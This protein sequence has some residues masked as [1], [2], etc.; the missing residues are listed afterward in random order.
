MS[1]EAS[2]TPLPFE[3]PVQA[4]QE[5]TWWGRTALRLNAYRATPEEQRIVRE[6]SRKVFWGGIVGTAVPGYFAIRLGRRYRWSTIRRAV[7]FGAA[8]SFGGYVGTIMAAASA[9]RAI[10]SMPNSQLVNIFKQ[11]INEAAVEQG[12]AP[13]YEI[14][15][16]E[17]FGDAQSPT[18]IPAE[19][20]PWEP[21]TQPAP[22]SNQNSSYPTPPASPTPES[23]PW[24]ALRRG[25]PRPSPPSAQSQTPPP[26]SESNPWSLGSTPSTGARTRP[27]EENNPWS[28]N[29]DEEGR[30]WGPD[31]DPWAKEEDPWKAK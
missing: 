8:A 7:A 20:K 3:L 25:S 18:S 6:N 12:M 4:G 24:A 22:T 11:A 10:M 28:K 21:V 15:P 17:T 29:K 16:L 23:D 30:M 27:Y 9:A 14:T 13:K 19:D 31:A 26:P 1:D 5:N 2:R